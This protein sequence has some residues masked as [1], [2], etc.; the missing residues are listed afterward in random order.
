MDSL[1]DKKVRMDTA[2]LLKTDHRDLAEILQACR[3]IDLANIAVPSKEMGFL[4][5]ALQRMARYV[6]ELEH[7][8]SGLHSAITNLLID[9][10]R[11]S[12]IEIALTATYALADLGAASAGA[13]DRLCELITSELREDEHP[14]VTM[15][16]IALRMVRRL[17][18]EIAT[19]YVDTSA[20]QEYKRTIAHWIDSGASKSDDVNLELQAEKHWIQAQE[21]RRTMR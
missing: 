11:H 4:A 6:N 3:A 16:G 5:L 10:T 13:F 1:A 19:Q 18:P 8:D 12:A 17:E 9:L 14:V 15:R 20:F 21:E 7:D 2:D